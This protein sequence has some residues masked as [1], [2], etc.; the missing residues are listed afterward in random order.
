M[1]AEQRRCVYTETYNEIYER[2]KQKYEEESG[3]EFD[4]VSDI[5]IRLKVLAGEIYNAQ[6]NYEW[7]KKQMFVT[8][9][10][11]EYLD[12]IAAQ[13]GLKRKKATKAQGDIR[14]SISEPIDHTI[15]IPMGTVVATED[16]EPLRFC[17][18]EDL[19]ITAGNTLV[20][21]Y[22][23]AEKAGSSGNIEPGKAVVPVS[24][25][26]EV[27]VV[28]NVYPFTDGTDEE[29]DI[30]LRERIR[31]SFVSQSNGTNSAFYEQL[32]LSVE[33]VAKVGVIPKVRGTGTVN[34]FV[35]GTDSAVSSATLAKVQALM[36]E[37]REL[38]VDVKVYDAA[39][40]K[41]DLTVTVVSKPGYSASEVTE[42]CIQ[43]FTNYINSLPVGSKLY[44]SAIGKHLLET[45]CIENYEFGNYM[46]NESV[47]GAECFKVGE[48]SITVE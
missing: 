11:G 34:V 40:V 14:F 7:L 26:A 38:N 23:E 47:S 33:G 8:T 9:A 3:S 37:K 13:R 22:A 1:K 46:Q 12:Y 44:L 19:E 45:D 21:I 36:D 20:F 48:I 17:T 41:Y 25:P 35:C 15:I 10:S 32:A 27:E 16:P 18:T 43:A 24:V 42:K 5:A 6:T 29:S 31:K 4:E 28:T 2:M 39:F 30:E